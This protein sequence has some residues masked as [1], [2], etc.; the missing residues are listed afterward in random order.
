MSMSTAEMRSS[1]AVVVALE[2]SAAAASP[3]GGEMNG[4]GEMGGSPSGRREL[5]SP[6][7]GASRQSASRAAAWSSAGLFFITSTTT[8][9][10]NKAIFRVYSFDAPATLVTGQMLFS[11]G[12]LYL[13]SIIFGADQRA[14]A[15]GFSIRIERPCAKSLLRVG[16]LSALFLTKLLLDMSALSLINIPMYGVLKSFTSVF[17][18]ALDILLRQKN[19]LHS[20]R[21][22]IEKSE[23][24]S[25]SV[26][27]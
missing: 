19:H 16:P 11:I 23:S 5:L 22:W 6:R 12:L 20:T 26:R 9:F 21:V 2:P 4:V 15:S 24:Y 7:K 18:I 13:S 27:W 17:V 8:V 10:I 1:S 3:F 14:T 25:I